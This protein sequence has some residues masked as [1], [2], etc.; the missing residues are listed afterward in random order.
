MAQQSASSRGL[1]WPTICLV[2]SFYTAFVSLTWFWHDLPW[3]LCWPAAAYLT[4]LYASLQHEAIHGHPTP[5]RRVNEVMVL[6]GL[7][8]WVPYG[9]FRD[10]HMRHHTDDRLTDPYDDPESFYWSQQDWARLWT[11]VQ[12]LFRANNT[13]AGRLM[14]GP[15]ISATR[16]WWHELRLLTTGDRDVAR[17]W[18]QHLPAL[19][20]LYLWISI[21]CGIPAWVY[22]AAFAYPGTALILLRSFAEHRAHAKAGARTAIVETCPAMALLFLN[23]NLHAVHHARPELAWYKLPRAYRAHRETVL[24]GNDGYLITGYL[25]LFAKYFIAA[26]EPVPHPLRDHQ[27]I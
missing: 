14:I 4:G 15:A 18:L 2:S 6:P 23:N 7:L 25:Q 27:T 21:I 17:A 22:L 13:L 1:E 16:F 5:W 12:A 19:A 11:P 8:A 26:K 10:L 9:R 24:G 20:I 3:W